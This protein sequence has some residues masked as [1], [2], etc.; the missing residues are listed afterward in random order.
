VRVLLAG[1][2]TRAIAESAVRAGCDVVT[3]DYFG[4]LDTKR[5]APNTSLRE[6]GSAY[7][8]AAL[9]QAARGVAYDA[10]AYSGG[11]E[12]HPEVLEGLVEGKE[13]LGNAP[14]TLRSVRD[15]A[16]LFPFLAAGGFAVPRTITFGQSAS[17]DL[18]TTGRWLVKPVASGGGHGIR[19]WRGERPDPRQ[20]LQQY[21]AGIPASAAFVADGRRA[22]LLGWSEQLHAPN[23][24]RYGGNLLPL[25]APTA[26]LEEL[27]HLIQAL[28]ARFGLVGLNGVDFVLRE[29]RP[30]VV[31]VNPRYSASMELVERATGAAMFALHVAGCRGGLPEATLADAA[32]RATGPSGVRGKA[33]V[34]APRA[35]VVAA[36]LSW[37]ERG[38]RDVPHPGDVIAKGRPICTVLA[39]G[40]SRAGCLAELRAAEADIVT[41][42]VPSDAPTS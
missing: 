41:S 4:D 6:R 32:L 42:C 39:D 29:T 27:R 18:P 16:V 38:V 21:V 24:F 7:S 1:L 19:R 10:V 9:A 22:V 33:I 34:Y 28:T 40:P 11:L 17:G 3:V 8:A 14:Q 30:V 35:V 5:L 31:E 26:T 15:P 23:R 25:D 12:N 13:L 36:S 37:M 20:I 2:S